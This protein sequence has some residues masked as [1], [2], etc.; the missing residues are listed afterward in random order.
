MSHN[1]CIHLLQKPLRLLRRD[2]GEFIPVKPT[3]N[4]GNV[5]ISHI[6][7]QK[8]IRKDWER[9]LE[10]V[11]IRRV[12]GEWSGRSLRREV[13]GSHITLIDF[14]KSPR[15][16]AFVHDNNIA[17]D[18]GRCKPPRREASSI[19][20]MAPPKIQQFIMLY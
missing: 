10:K 16:D 4:I 11:G 12:V 18:K 6:G 13:A 20:Q 9:L 3:W 14:Q 2:L 19:T 8:D 17:T 15:P 1:R 5:M 7:L